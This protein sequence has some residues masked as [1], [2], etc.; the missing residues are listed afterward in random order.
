VN[1]RPLI[2]TICVIGAAV[3]V[4]WPAGAVRVAVVLFAAIAGALI[5]DVF[6]RALAGIE[7]MRPERPGLRSRTVDRT[8]PLELGEMQRE[9]SWSAALQP[10][11][12]VVFA[13]VQALA[14]QRVRGRLGLD[15]AQP[16][17]HAALARQV[18]P[19]LFTLV[20]SGL[21]AG[22]DS[23]AASAPGAVLHRTYV[24]YHLRP[25]MASLPQIIEEMESL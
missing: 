22:P 24:P 21:T 20:M 13:R 7:P 23:D 9:L 5:L 25:T 14:R 15:P 3:A 1:V 10:M 19:L 11:P 6:A 16:R 4:L 2:V 17:D 18:P 12:D 8:A